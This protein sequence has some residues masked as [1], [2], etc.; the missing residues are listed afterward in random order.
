MINRR[1]FLGSATAAVALLN[2]QPAPSWGGKVLDIHHHF[3][4]TPNGNFEHMDGCGVTHAVLL[5]NARDEDKAKAEVAQHRDRFIR[6]TSA[7]VTKPENFDVLRNSVKTGG[8]GYGEIKYRVAVDSPEMRRLYAV[9]AELN[10]PV[11]LHFQEADDAK[12]G[13][14][15]NSGFSRF[16]A[17]L[18][19]FPK[20]TFIGHANFFWASISADP[21]LGAAYP[22]GKIKP[23]GL[24]DRMLGDYP[25]L[26]GDTSANSGRN[27][28]ARD[29]EF[30]AGFLK[31]HQDKLMFGSD[32]PCRDGR[33]TGQVSQEPL[34]KG[35]CVARETLAELKQSASPEI[36]KKI[37]W[38]NGVKLFRP[39]F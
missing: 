10:V 22:K 26:Y 29:P 34:I 24:T 23:G 36:F 2:A 13:G 1:Q 16:P 9:A 21:Q 28:L 32:C 15:F 8:K 38:E 27:A 17:I 11:L 25:N 33:G 37:T 3:R 30:T 19:E 6:F 5:T 18:K 4:L 14:G 35:K 20:T 39:N 7:D 31:R 12:D